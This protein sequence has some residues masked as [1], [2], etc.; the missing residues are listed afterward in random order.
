MQYTAY[1]RALPALNAAEVAHADAK[2]LSAALSL[3][4]RPEEVPQAPRRRRLGYSLVMS[5][6]PGHDTPAGP[7]LVETLR[8]HF[9]TSK[10]GIIAAFLFGSHARR[11]HHCQSDVDVALLLDRGSYIALDDPL[12]YRADIASRLI[13]ELHMNEVDVL[14][15]NEAPPGLAK[16][17]IDEGIELVVAD[18]AALNDFTALTLSRAADLAPWLAKWRREHLRRIADL[19]APS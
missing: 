17:V 12:A 7:E 4:F 5:G 6:S 14:L 9:A 11:E 13:G 3:P 19:G 2:P 8:A 15:L 18:R 10:A 16:E 1:P